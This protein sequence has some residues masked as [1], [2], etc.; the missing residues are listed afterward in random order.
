M[1][2]GRR[3]S[4]GWA[5]RR[6]EDGP[7]GDRIP[8]ASDVLREPTRLLL[9]NDLA[10]PTR[11]LPAHGREIPSRR[12][13]PLAPRRARPARAALITPS[14]WRRLAAHATIGGLPP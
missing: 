3:G 13:L 6:R 14:D 12:S 4:F 5:S 10:E 2:D 7:S 1:V 9:G 8:T 11:I